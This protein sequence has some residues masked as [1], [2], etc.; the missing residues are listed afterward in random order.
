[1][2]RTHDD[3]FTAPTPAGRDPRRGAWSRVGLPRDGV[4]NEEAPSGG[5]GKGRFVATNA[6]VRERSGW[7]TFAA[8][9]LFSVGFLR[10]VSGISYFKNSAAIN[11]LTHGAFHSQ[12]WAWGVWD[13]CVAALA[14]L[15][16]LALVGGAEFLSV[17][18]GKTVAYLWAIL[19]I[20]QG[21]ML[22]GQATWYSA[23]MIGLA[24]LVI[25]GLASQTV[26]EGV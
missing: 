21:F 23:L 19:V 24:V 9:V 17:G 8:V 25:W 13:I 11:D 4:Y 26:G 10:I 3:T 16:G 18:F 1:L 7:L 5:C 15:A 12:L 14:I 22:I 20:V 6:S 2:T